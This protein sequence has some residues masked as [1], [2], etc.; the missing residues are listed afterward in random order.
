MALISCESDDYAYIVEWTCNAG[1]FV[2]S[3]CSYVRYALW[4]EWGC[5]TRTGQGITIG[6][7]VDTCVMFWLAKPKDSDKT[8]C[9]YEPITRRVDWGDVNDFVDR[10]RGNRGK[11]NASNFHHCV[12]WYSEK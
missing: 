10:L 4:K 5:E 11:C 3:S 8:F 9:F 12:H 1:F 7:S 6:G 2:E